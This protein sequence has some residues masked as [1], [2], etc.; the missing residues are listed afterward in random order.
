MDNRFFN[1]YPYTDFHELNL[2][3]VISELRSFATTL[4]QFVSI[5]ALKY[6][7]PIQW[8]IT[9]QY[10]KNTI[11]IDP[12]TGVA[13]ISVAAVPSGV[14][15]TNTDYWT[16][17]FDLGSF[18]VKAAKNFTSNYEEAT[19]LTA[20]MSLNAGDWVI[21]GDTL[22]KALV[23]IT[24]GDSY[25]VDGNIKQF[26]MEDV[27]G[28]L[29]DLSTTDKSNL[30]AAINE[31][32]QALVDTAG[33]LDNLTTT[34]KSNLVAAINEVL[35]ALVDT[36]GDLDNLT[37]TDKSNLVAAIN[38]VLQALVDTAGDLGDISSLN[39]TD[40]TSAV[41]AINEVYDMAS[42]IVD[43]WEVIDLQPFAQDCST[44][45]SNPFPQGGCV[46]ERNGVMYVLSILYDSNTDDCV[47]TLFDYDSNTQIYQSTSIPSGH[48]NSVT[49]YNGYFYCSRGGDLYVYKVPFDLST[50]TTV[51]MGSDANYSIYY[52]EGD[53]YL[54]ERY[55]VFEVIDPDTLEIKKHVVMDDIVSPDGSATRAFI[56]V[57]DDKI[58]LSCNQIQGHDAFSFGAY[59]LACRGVCI[60][61]RPV[62]W[63]GACAAV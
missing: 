8:N 10:E 41:N 19:T 31:A 57:D 40:K 44:A 22:Y 3:W 38:E 53:F 61:R 51:N 35:Q 49:Y 50:Y 21:W 36:A 39:T 5:N 43:L 28:H 56:A 55:G 58:F 30:V 4:E 46:F 52:Y 32:L 60:F 34:D 18:V 25:V 14:A 47:W 11:V 13:Y 16:V 26:T 1:S 24:A 17:V 62:H 15:L 23:N 29:E 7:D 59:N 9:T 48:S 37:T 54:A 45:I 2:S 6:A 42:N 33:D 12:V 20:T 27:I 63:R